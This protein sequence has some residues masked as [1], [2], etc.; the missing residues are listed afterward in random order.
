MAVLLQGESLV[1]E[2]VEAMGVLVPV[3]DDTR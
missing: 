1:S 3:E 2:Q